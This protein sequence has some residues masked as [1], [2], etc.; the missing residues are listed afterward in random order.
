[1]KP[2][3]EWFNSLKPKQKTIVTII[4]IVVL[5]GAFQALI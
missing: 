1:M 3:V 5:I 4:G 2:I